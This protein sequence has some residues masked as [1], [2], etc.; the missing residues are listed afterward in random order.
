ME[1]RISDLEVSQVVVLAQLLQTNLD[2]ADRQQLQVVLFMVT[3]AQLDVESQFK[4]E[5]LK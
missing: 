3:E 5:I 1:N 2:A 4:M